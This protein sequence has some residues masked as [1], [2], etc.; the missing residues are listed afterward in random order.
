MDIKVLDVDEYSAIV[1]EPFS[2]F[3]SD[4]FCKLNQHKVDTIIPLIGVNSKYRFGLIVGIKGNE[5]FAPFSAPFSCISNISSQNKALDYSEFIKNLILFAKNSKFKKIKITL[6]PLFYDQNHIQWIINSLYTN[7]FTISGAD[8]AHYINLETYK[9]FE[10]DYISSLSIKGRQK[11]SSSLKENMTCEIT[12]DISA[13][14]KIIEENRKFR[15]YPL[16]VKEE[17]LINTS[18]HIKIDS[19]LVRSS[20][21]EI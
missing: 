18:K 1:V 12:S 16:R 3:D 17:D 9:N 20:E 5:M 14:Y 15:G 21:N 7:G 6:P 19:F 11:I 4:V 10:D 13:A 8:I 2:A